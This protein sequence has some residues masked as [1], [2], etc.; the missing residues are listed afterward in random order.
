MS[1]VR[2]ALFVSFLLPA[3][4]GCRG[5]LELFLVACLTNDLYI[6]QSLFWKNKYRVSYYHLIVFARN[7]VC[8]AAMGFFLVVFVVVTCFP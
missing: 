5:V 1:A 4:E 3:V 2:S 7:V 6:I 8:G